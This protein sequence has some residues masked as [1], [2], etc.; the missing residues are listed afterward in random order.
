MMKPSL[1]ICL[2]P[3]QAWIAQQL[4]RQKQPAPAHLLMICY[5][6][7]DNDKF[8]HYYQ[9]TAALCEHSDYVVLS[10]NKWCR[11]FMLPKLQKNIAKQYDTVYLANV[12]SESVHYV[13]SH[14]AFNHLE[15]FDDGTAN[16]YPNSIFY[17]TQ[18]FNLIKQIYRCLQG[19]RYQT[20]D[21]RELSQQ[22]HT[23]YP[24]LPNIVAHTT[25]LRL[26]HDDLDILSKQPAQSY[27]ILLGQP[28]FEQAEDNVD[29]FTTLNRH[30]QADAYFPHPRESYRLPDVVY[31]QTPLI[32]E[33]YLIAE[34]QKQ[35]ARSFVVYSLGSSAALNV[36]AFPHVQVFALRPNLPL[37]DNEMWTNLYRIQSQLNIPI[38]DI[39]L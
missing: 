1:Y 31:I 22:H 24:Q 11:K 26:W 29:L 35:P 4:I 23:L 39:T 28:L 7:A 25:P 15:T 18:T 21:L 30:I 8:H 3:L 20:K 36:N 5:A 27:K 37:F 16:L 32:F 10:Q 33:D 9:Q 19:I 38:H 6:E 14:I 17:Q 13:L 2:T 34:I 12:D